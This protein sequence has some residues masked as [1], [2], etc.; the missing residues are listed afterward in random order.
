MGNMGIMKLLGINVEVGIAQIRI[1]LKGLTEEH[2]QRYNKQEPN[3]KYQKIILKN[4]Y[5][6]PEELIE[7]K[8]KKEYGINN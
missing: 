2:A 6:I 4:I 5:K 3:T 8:L 1:G 7:R